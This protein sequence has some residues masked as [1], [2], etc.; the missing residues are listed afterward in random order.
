MNRDDNF[1]VGQRVQW[2]DP[3]LLD[4]EPEDRQWV[5][6]RIFR[7]VKFLDDDYDSVLIAEINGTSEAEVYVSELVPLESDWYS[8]AVRL[9]E[10]RFPKI[11]S[12]E[13][14]DFVLFYW[15][16]LDE[17]DANISTFVDYINGI[18]AS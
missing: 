9:L 1:Y 4:Y 3:G 15:N 10:E 16:N 18:D 7:I 17:D 12:H 14:S 11:S 13:L 6:D 8:R 2:N 5:T